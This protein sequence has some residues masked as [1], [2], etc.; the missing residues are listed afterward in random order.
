MLPQ[1][2]LV[3]VPGAFFKLFGFFLMGDAF[4]K[5]KQIITLGGSNMGFF[6]EMIVAI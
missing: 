6:I 5:R 3:T 1:Q 2:T 4:F